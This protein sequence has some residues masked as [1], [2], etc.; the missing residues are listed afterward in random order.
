VVMGGDIP[1]GI[2]SSARHRTTVVG[3]TTTEPVQPNDGGGQ[4]W[5]MKRR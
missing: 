5:E 4:P 3:V 2:W 1:P